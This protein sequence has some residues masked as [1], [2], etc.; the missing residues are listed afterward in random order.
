M[1][2]GMTENKTMRMVDLFAGIAGLRQGVQR[3]LKKNGYDTEVVFTSEIKPAA[4]E[5]LQLNFPKETI[6]G[7]ITQV[8]AEDIP[9]HEI[10]MAGFPCQAFSAAGA[11]RGF[12]DT[13][14]TL[15]YDVARILKYHQTE[16]FVLENVPGLLTHDNGKT[17]NVI[18]TTLKELGYHTTYQVLNGID[19]GVPQARQRIFIWGSLH[20]PEVIKKI[21][22]PTEKEHPVLSDFLEYGTAPHNESDKDRKIRHLLETHVGVD[23][24]RGKAIHDKR[25][26]ATSIHSWDINARGELSDDAKELLVAMITERNSRKWSSA[27][28]IPH[29]TDIP[30]TKEDIKTFYTGSEEFDDV[31]ESITSQGYLKWRER[32]GIFGYTIPTGQLSFGYFKILDDNS[33]STTLVATDL[34]GLSVVDGNHIRRFTET[35]LKRLFGFAD[36]YK[37]HPTKT[38]RSKLRDVFGNSVVVNVSEGLTEQ[39]FSDIK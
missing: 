19:F 35:E 10:L 29:S 38:S 4:K 22:G 12:E 23:N 39:I 21:V 18:M 25:K 6:S 36:D 33:Y 28:N 17:I 26:S 11:R 8:E 20:H 37:I 16:Y 27:K 5:I 32:L 3:G 30:L 14:G 24:L 2:K 31:F 34:D 15:F 13:R 9:E 7:D 1:G